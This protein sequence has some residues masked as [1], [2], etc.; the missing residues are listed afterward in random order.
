M[1]RKENATK[2]Y[3]NT[4]AKLLCFHVNDKLFKN[5]ITNIFQL[6][7]LNLFTVY[8]NSLLLLVVLK[9][10]R[11]QTLVIPFVPKNKMK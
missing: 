5:L 1:K 6:L 4:T 11:R 2:C 3:E 9:K 8:S 7:I 10:L